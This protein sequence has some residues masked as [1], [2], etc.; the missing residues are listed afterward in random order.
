MLS[1]LRLEHNAIIDAMAAG[2]QPRNEST[3]Q[4]IGKAVQRYLS[5]ISL[6]DYPTITNSS[7]FIWIQQKLEPL[8]Q[9]VSSLVLSISELLNPADRP[10][11]INDEVL[12]HAFIESNFVAVLNKLKEVVYEE[13]Q[14]NISFAMISTPDFFN[15]TMKSLLLSALDTVGIE[16][17]KKTTPRTYASILGSGA[18][19][20]E[21]VISID[22]GEFHFVMASSNDFMWRTL[23]DRRGYKYDVPP[24]SVALDEFSSYNNIDHILTNAVIEDNPWIKRQIARGA[25]RH[26]LHAKIT[27]ARAQIKDSFDAEVMGKGMDEDHHHEEWPLHLA[28]WGIG[29]DKEEGAGEVL[30]WESVQAVE[31]N[32]VTML[33]WNLRT[34]L[35]VTRRKLSFCI[36]PMFRY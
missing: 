12:S 33:C 7:Q 35:I 10:F 14:T 24:S 34:F 9:S 13:H 32:Y 3:I 4:T 5:I 20:G 1:R 25:N 22:H 26:V 15:Y 8:K 6:A 31:E 36:V 28:G 30:K 18:V 21:R 16:H 27:L 19:E 17:S 23:T 29:D 11:T 2:V